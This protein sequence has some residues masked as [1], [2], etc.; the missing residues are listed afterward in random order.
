MT[1]PQLALCISMVL[2]AAIVSLAS[3][4]VGCGSSSSPIG[5][6]PPPPGKISH[7]VIIFQE[8]RT[9]DNLFQGLCTANGGVPGCDP[10]GT[11]PNQYD[12]ASQGMTST[13]TVPLT[14]VTLATNYDLGH[15]HDSFLLVCDYNASAG[16]CKMDGAN[17]NV[18]DPAPNCPSL[19]ENQ[20]VQPSDVQPYLT[21]AQTYTFGDRMF[22]TNQGPSFPAHQYILSGT[23]AISASSTTYVSDNPG[24]NLRANG[25]AGSGCLA[26]PTASENTLDITQPFPNM[27]YSYLVGSAEC[28]EHPTLTDVLDSNHLTWK[29]YTPEDGFI[30]TAPNGIDHICQPSG[31]SDQLVCEGPDWTNTN[32]NVVVEGSG[33]QIVT[34]IQSGKLANVTWVIPTGQNSDHAGN[35]PSNGPSW[36][37]SI[38]NAIGN[39]GFWSDTAIIVTW[40]DWGGWY[41]H[42]PPTLLSTNSYEYGYRVPLL[43]ISPYAKPAYISHQVDDFG[44]I[45]KFIEETFSLPAIDPSVGYADSYTP[46]DLSDCFD[47][48]QTPITFTTIQAPVPAEHFI[49][50]KSKPEPPDND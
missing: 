47:Y 43:V 2:L 30:W 13:G 11:N 37:A 3:I 29:Y 34:D 44:S 14:P 33:A 46:G 40:D 22:Q 41:D 17:T 49:H 39:S 27:A 26:P 32:P 36:V 50:D 4:M 38:V 5:V 18:C 7:V 25:T 15:S 48:N 20:Y 45:L 21:M 16:T 9:P 23:S 42:V 1:R 35:T 31:P 12:I 6:T 28:M 10:T 19:P 8:N 24:N